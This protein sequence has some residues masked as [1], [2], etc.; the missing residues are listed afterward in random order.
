MRNCRRDIACKTSSKRLVEREMSVSGYSWRSDQRTP[1]LWTHRPFTVWVSKPSSQSWLMVRPRLHPLVCSLAMLTLTGT[2][3]PS[4]YCF[5]RSFQAEA[6]GCW[7]STFEPERWEPLLSTWWH[8]FGYINLPVGRGGGRLFKDR[9]EAVILRIAMF[10]SSRLMHDT[11]TNHG[12]KSKT[13]GLGYK[14][15]NLQRLPEGSTI[16]ARIQTITWQKA[17]CA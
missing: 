10:T 12:Q 9:D 16:L 17:F 5:R 14:Y 3:W 4:T 7:L 13:Q 2:K 8:G 11:S 1:V 6:L 15:W